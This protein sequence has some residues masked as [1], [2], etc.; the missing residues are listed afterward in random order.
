M[1]LKNNINE[2]IDSNENNNSNEINKLTLS[3][4]Y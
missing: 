4:N 2:E 3:K 1:K